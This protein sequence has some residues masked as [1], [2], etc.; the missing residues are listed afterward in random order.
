MRVFHNILVDAKKPLF[1]R[2]FHNIHKNHKTIMNI[3]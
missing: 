3:Y 1:M 2:V